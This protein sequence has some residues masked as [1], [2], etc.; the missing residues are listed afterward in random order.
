VCDVK[1]EVLALPKKIS[2]KKSEWTIFIPRH[3]QCC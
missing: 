2:W 3:D 1:G